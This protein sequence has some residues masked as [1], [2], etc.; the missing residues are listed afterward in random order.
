MSSN[1]NRSVAAGLVLIGVGSI[2][3]L[4]NRIEGIGQP[5]IL[6]VLGTIFL[7]GY[8]YSRQYGLMVPAGILLGLGAG[9]LAEEGW[10]EFGDPSKLGLGA[11][12]IAIFL[13]P[14]IVEHRSHWWPLIPGAILVLLGFPDTE[15]AVRWLFDNWPVILIGVGVLV[16]LGGLLRRP[17]A[18]GPTTDEGPSRSD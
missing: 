8:V 9:S 6:L 13:V 15:K 3:F 17:R 14:L 1:R 7:A 18:E 4:L 11:G 5:A 16:L 2:L 10:L 12:F